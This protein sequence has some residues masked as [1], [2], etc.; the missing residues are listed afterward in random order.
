M[1]DLSRIVIL[2]LQGSGKKTLLQG[3][4][5]YFDFDYKQEVTKRVECANG[6]FDCYPITI[7][8]KYYK[9]SIEIAVCPGDNAKLTDDDIRKVVGKNCQGVIL[10]CTSFDNKSL[11]TLKRWENVLKDCNDDYE[12]RLVICSYGDIHNANTDKNMVAVKNWCIDNHYEFIPCN[13]RLPHLT[14]KEQEKEGVARVV[15]DLECVMWN[16]IDTSQHCTTE[17][18]VDETAIVS[19]RDLEECGCCRKSRV[20]DSITLYRCSRCKC[21]SYCSKDCQVKDWKNHKAFCNQ[22]AGLGTAS[23]EK[24]VEEKRLK[25]AEN[26]LV[27]ALPSIPKTKEEEDMDRF[28]KLLSDCRATKENARLLPD[29]ERKKRAAEITARIMRELDLGSAEEIAQIEEDLKQESL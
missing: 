24:A 14:W 20:R 23:K 25:E 4:S 27:G 12:L 6:S 5:R 19:A 21:I 16:S 15:E 2:G 18:V 26:H 7:F 8:T 1:S 3:L 9:A 22:V 28:S 10:M 17:R 11:E 29:N 13:L